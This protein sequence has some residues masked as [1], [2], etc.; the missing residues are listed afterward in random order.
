MP[1]NFVVTRMLHPGSTTD[2][3]RF[4]IEMPVV[5]GKVCM[6]RQVHVELVDRVRTQSLY[7]QDF[8]LS[9]DP[10]HTLVSMLQLDSTIFLKGRY[11]VAQPT[12]V[13]FQVMV[14]PEKFLYPEGIPCPHSRLPFFIQN[15]NTSAADTDWHVTIFFELVKVTAQEMAVAVV[16]RG[17]GVTRD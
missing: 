12:I 16:R 6:I 17:R 11:V 8:A 7:D 1:L 15:S 14:N 9:A 4:F 13:G 10:D 2:I 3:L 5:P